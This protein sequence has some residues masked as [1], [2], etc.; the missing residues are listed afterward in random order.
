MPVVVHIVS[1]MSLI[2]PHT[3]GLFILTPPVLT[4]ESSTSK[5]K[6]EMDIFSNAVS[7][8]CATNVRHLRG[9]NCQVY[10]RTQETQ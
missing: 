4:K 5:S 3:A 7:N 1:Y 9:K 2:T 8:S 10:F 6:M